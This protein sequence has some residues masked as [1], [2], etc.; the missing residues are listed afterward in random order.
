M[1]DTG[2]L[3][4]LLRINETNQLMN[5]EYK[6]ML[7]TGYL[8]YNGNKVLSFGEHAGVKLYAV[9]IYAVK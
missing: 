4:H 6:G 9:P 5:S 2:I 3:C 1:C 7:K 8:M